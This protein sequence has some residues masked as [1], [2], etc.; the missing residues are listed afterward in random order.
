MSRG[1][2]SAAY[3]EQDRLDFVAFIVAHTGIAGRALDVGC[4][5][6]LLGS[7]LMKH[8]WTVYGVEPEAEIAGRAST[9][10]HKVF[11][12]TFPSS[13]VHEG[14]P[15]DAIVFG[16]SLEHM[17][18]PWDALSV[19]VDLLSDDGVLFASVPN[20]S[21]L[22]VVRGLLRGRWQYAESGLLDSTHL[23]F[24]TPSSFEEALQAVGLEVFGRHA[25]R[26]GLRRGAKP[27]EWLLA[28]CAP[29]MLAFQFYV[30]ARKC[31]GDARA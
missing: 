29:H 12:E 5:G 3:Y 15:Y 16:D 10:L 14:A 27:V 11:C 26:P 24:F 8:G 20:V 22:S 1:S 19:A 18:D 7:A 17:Q 31:G 9:R 6:G 2:D 13:G 30:A 21:H 23:R 4:A 25:V 28:S